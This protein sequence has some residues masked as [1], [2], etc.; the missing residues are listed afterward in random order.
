MLDDRSTCA[1]WG[2][3]RAR[4]IH[5]VS[6]ALKLAFADRERYYGDAARR[7]SP[8]LS[9]A[10]VRERAALIRMDRAGQAPAPGDPRG[11]APAG[12]RDGGGRR[13]P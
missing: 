13:R 11:T 4:Y 8:A 6:E 7:V 2:T 9:P 10:Y 12:G 3:T 5:I 1:R